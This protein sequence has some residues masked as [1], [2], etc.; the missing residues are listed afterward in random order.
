ML[1]RSSRPTNSCCRGSRSQFSK[2]MLLQSWELL[3]RELLF[4]ILYII[5]QY[6]IY[7]IIII[8]INFILQNHCMLIF[9]AL[10]LFHYCTFIV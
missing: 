5:M 1:H 10:K 7:Y 8:I 6:Y 3:V 9:I 4:N 2:G